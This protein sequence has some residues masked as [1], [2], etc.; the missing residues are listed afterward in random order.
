MI[1][2]KERPSVKV[3]PGRILVTGATG[4]VGRQ[5]LQRLRQHGAAVRVARRA[6]KSEESTTETASARPEQS[7]GLDFT[8]PETF[9]DA[10][11]GCDAVFLLRP[12]SIANMRS[13]LKPFIDQA[14]AGGVRHIVFLSV[15]GAENNRMIP[16]RAVEDYLQASSM[17]WTLLRAGFF[18]NNLGDAYRRD[19]VEE[20]RLY[21]PAGA[22]RVA[23]IDAEDIADVAVAALLTPQ[24]H[25]SKAYWL[26][27][28]EALS[29]TQVAA[30]LT[31]ELGR[32]IR[33]EPASIA[34]YAWHLKTRRALPLVQIAVQSLLHVGL[35]SGAA[36]PVSLQVAALLDRPP[37]T[38]RDY[39]RTNRALW[40]SRPSSPEK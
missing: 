37:R 4:N 17:D 12:P 22:G 36:E 15:A 14:A 13:T 3:P 33:Y 40:K 6:G 25:A 11:R 10:V 1:T 9:A 7:V 29:F 34:G 27:G 31:Q 24:A 38:L 21:V 18:A 30:L 39:I 2:D 35:R 28:P 19:I 20:A 16:H 26:T 8:C 5:V 23:F 32:P